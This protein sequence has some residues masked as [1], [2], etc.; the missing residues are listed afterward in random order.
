MR[1]EKHWIDENY[2]Q[3]MSVESW[4]KILIS[5]DDKI[6]FHGKLRQLKAKNLGNGI[7]EVYKNER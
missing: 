6:I 1:N 5:N 7:V 3:R 4:K 2:K